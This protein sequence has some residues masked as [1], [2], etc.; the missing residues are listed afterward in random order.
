VL[1]L[2]AL[3]AQPSEADADAEAETA[4]ASV[5]GE[6]AA[7]AAVA[8]PATEEPETVVR[9]I[10]DTKTA[11]SLIGRQ[12]TVPVFEQRIALEDGIGSDFCS[13]E[14]LPCV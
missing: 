13:L 1:V 14:A 4:M 3:P 5:E 8:V 10:I 11:G 6:V 9:A 7:A 2:F 12:G